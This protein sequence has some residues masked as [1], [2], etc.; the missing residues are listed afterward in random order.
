MAEGWQVQKVNPGLIFLASV[1]P[2]LAAGGACFVWAKL[3]NPEPKLLHWMPATQI[4][5][6]RC[7]K[8]GLD[9]PAT[10]L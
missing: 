7:I 3:S 1:L 5:K 2:P 4:F 10:S 6:P 9:L 8:R